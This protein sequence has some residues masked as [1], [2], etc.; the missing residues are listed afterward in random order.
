MVPVKIRSNLFRCRYSYYSV[1]AGRI[2]RDDVYFYKL[3]SVVSH[4]CFILAD[5]SFDNVFWQDFDSFKFDVSFREFT[6]DRSLIKDY[7]L[8]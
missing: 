7:A 1:S 8:C 2:V 4:L 6:V 3:V 5:S